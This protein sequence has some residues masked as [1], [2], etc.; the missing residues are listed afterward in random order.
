MIILVLTAMAGT[1]MIMAPY[2]ENLSHREDANRYQ[3]LGSQLLL[4]TGQPSDW[5]QN[6]RIPTIIGLAQNGT[7][8]PYELDMDKLS[9]INSMN[10][11]SLP[12][13]DL[14]RIFGV[15][16]ITFEIT[17]KP[18]FTLNATVVSDIVNGTAIDYEFRIITDKDGQYVPS[19]I[20]GYL[21][22]DDFTA[23]AKATSHEGNTYLDF[24]VPASYPGSAVV[25]FFAQSTADQKIA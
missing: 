10:D 9:R 13:S 19:N 16:D 15:K 25:I 2:L 8:Q 18:F 7:Q 1:T 5:G 11:F 24:D 20:V 14:W 6:N 17:V 4:N 12:Y 3:S 23:N 22:V 21:M